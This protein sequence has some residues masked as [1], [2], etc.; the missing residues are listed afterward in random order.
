MVD[1]FKAATFSPDRVYRYR[2]ER[3]ACV[4]PTGKVLNIIGLNPSTADESIN[5]PTIRRCIAFAQSWG[6]DHLVMTNLFA[7]RATDPFQLRY[8]HALLAD[9]VGAENNRH[10]RDA[11]QEAD[12]VIAAW[13]HLGSFLNRDREVLNLL[14]RERSVYCLGIT[15]TGHPKHPLYL[16][17]TTRP[18]LWM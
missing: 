11:W 17:K 2:L 6:F 5:D 14:M 10:L 15:K 7:Y 16:P 9:L 12:L 18:V 4:P 1:Y 3:C 8:Q 13:G